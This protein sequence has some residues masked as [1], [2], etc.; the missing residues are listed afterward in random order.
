MSVY[1]NVHWSG[2]GHI[3]IITKEVICTWCLQITNYIHSY[4]CSLLQ[5]SPC[6]QINGIYS[7]LLK[8]SV[9]E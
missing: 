1:W 8:L 5:C 2:L 7:Q 6:E 9:F 4:V 3:I